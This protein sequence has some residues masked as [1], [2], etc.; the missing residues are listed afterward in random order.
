MPTLKPSLLAATFLALLASPALAEFDSKTNSTPTGSFHGGS[1]SLTLTFDAGDFSGG[2]VEDV[3]VDVTV[4]AGDDIDFGGNRDWNQLSAT[5]ESPVGTILQLMPTNSFS[6]G[7]P[8][9][10]VSISFADTGIALP[11]GGAPVT[12]TTYAPSGAGGFATFDGE[13]AIGVW[14][15]TFSDTTIVFNDAPT[16]F[17]SFTLNLTT[18]AVPEPGTWALF[19]LGGLGLLGVSRRRRRVAMAADATEA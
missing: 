14:T 11:G 8:L 12:G 9:G 3:T 6:E 7:G 2:I 19:A 5:L 16:N 10:P 4:E 17:Q 18:T 15:L 13:S 1:A